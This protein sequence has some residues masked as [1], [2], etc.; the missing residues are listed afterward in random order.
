[1]IGHA[2]THTDTHTL[3]HLQKWPKLEQCYIILKYSST[4]AVDKTPWTPTNVWLLPSVRRGTIGFHSWVKEPGS[5]LRYLLAPAPI[6]CDVNVTS[7][8]VDK[9]RLCHEVQG[10]TVVGSFCVAAFSVLQKKSFF[11]LPALL[12]VRTCCDRNRKMKVRQ[13]E[14]KLIAEVAFPEVLTNI[15]FNCSENFWA[16]KERI[17]DRSQDWISDHSMLSSDQ[18]RIVF[19]FIPGSGE[20]K[21]KTKTSLGWLKLSRFEIQSGVEVNKIPAP[22]TNFFSQ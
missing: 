20:V 1:M 5:G 14:S 7:G 3:Q 17:K 12:C 18:L 21:R 13:R 16:F 6:N 22:G 9:T 4:F 2:N 10:V 15:P 19:F 11:F 8:Q